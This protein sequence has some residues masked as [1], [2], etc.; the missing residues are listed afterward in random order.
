MVVVEDSEAEEGVASRVLEGEGVVVSRVLGG[1]AE[2][3]AEAGVA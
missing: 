3:E 1:G 2:E